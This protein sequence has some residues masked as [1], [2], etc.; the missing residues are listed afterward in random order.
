MMRQFL[1]PAGLAATKALVV[2]HARR[3]LVTTGW[4]HD[5][6]PNERGWVEQPGNTDPKRRVYFAQ[7]ITRRRTA[8]DF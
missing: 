6:Y 4:V 5:V 1:L 7:V 2:R 8:D 3:G